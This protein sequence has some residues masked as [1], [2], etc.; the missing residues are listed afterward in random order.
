MPSGSFASAL[1]VIP[2]PVPIWEPSL[3]PLIATVG[4]SRCS[5]T[6]A[7]SLAKPSA[8]RSVVI[9]TAST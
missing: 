3:G 1:S 2:T 4:L 9:P 7:S 6:Q 8:E 5:A